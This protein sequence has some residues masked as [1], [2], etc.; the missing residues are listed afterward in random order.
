M[1]T[2]LPCRTA[3]FCKSKKSMQS[4]HRKQKQLYALKNQKT[5]DKK[6]DNRGE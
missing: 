3:S 4:F 1:A 5:A 6:K 2:L